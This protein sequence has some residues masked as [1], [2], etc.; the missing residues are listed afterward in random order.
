[1]RAKLL[2]GLRSKSRILVIE[3]ITLIGGINTEDVFFILHEFAGMDEKFE[4]EDG[5][6]FVQFSDISS[7]KPRVI[8]GKVMSPCTGVSL[9]I[10]LQVVVTRSP[11]LHPGGI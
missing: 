2:R 8:T 1:M 3:G 9:F 4:L 10:S 11:C 6:C 7:N 5:E